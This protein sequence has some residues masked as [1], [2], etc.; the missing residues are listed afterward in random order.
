MCMLTS[1][2]QEVVRT[3]NTVIHQD[4]PNP[5]ISGIDTQP[6]A[7]VIGERFSSM[8]IV[9]ELKELY[10]PYSVMSPFETNRLLRPTISLKC[11][12]IF[13]GYLSVRILHNPVKMLFFFSSLM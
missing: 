1:R 6:F 9:E 4:S 2:E 5:L 11:S 3:V 7:S 12:C 10:N 13:Q 8:Q